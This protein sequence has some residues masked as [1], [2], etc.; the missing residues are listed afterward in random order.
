MIENNPREEIL[1]LLEGMGISIMGVASA[2]VL[3]S[4]DD[5]SVDPPVNNPPQA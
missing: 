5:R 1:R 2:D 3:L 4:G